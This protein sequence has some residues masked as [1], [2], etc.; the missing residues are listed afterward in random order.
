MVAL[1]QAIRAAV[2]SRKAIKPGVELDPSLEDIEVTA[3]RDRLERVLGHLIQNAS[4]AGDNKDGRILIRTGREE[5]QAVIEIT[6]NGHGMSEDF[7]REQLFRPFSST[8]AGGMGI[9]AFESREYIRELSGSIDVVSKPLAGTTFIVRLPLRA[10]LRS[11][12]SLASAMEAGV[13]RRG[14]V[15][16]GDAHTDS[17]GRS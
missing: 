14:D 2:W 11:P 5:G 8:K 9:G 6:D 7:I 13:A 3:H 4:E 15:E 16:R 12:V 10:P 17:A 1:S